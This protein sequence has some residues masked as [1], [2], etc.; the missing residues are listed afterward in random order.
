MTIK[1][2]APCWNP[3]PPFQGQRRG[4]TRFPPQAR[5]PARTK[6]RV[7]RLQSGRTVHSHGPI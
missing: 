4:Q 1:A 3:R 5:P 2:S 7:G 6:A